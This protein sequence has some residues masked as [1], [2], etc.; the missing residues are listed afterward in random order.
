MIVLTAEERVK[1][2][3][4]LKQEAEADDALARQADAIGI[5]VIAKQKRL[6]AIAKQAVAKELENTEVFT[7]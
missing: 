6:M 7:V 5:K 2:A 3:S 1:F 4:W